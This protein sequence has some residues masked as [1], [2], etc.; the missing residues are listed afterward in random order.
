MTGERQ[1]QI[2][3]G[4][5]QFEAAR[6]LKRFHVSE[7][8]AG[9]AIPAV[10]Y[11]QRKDREHGRHRKPVPATSQNH[12][13][14]P[15]NAPIDRR[16]GRIL[17][18]QFIALRELKLALGDRPLPSPTPSGRSSK[19]SVTS[20]TLWKQRWEKREA[21]QLAGA[22]QRRDRVERSGVVSCIRRSGR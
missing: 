11:W 18:R 16:P 3:D 6:T 4:Q 17:G 8:P 20:S 1:K 2:F 13:R 5:E 21:I 22:R 9:C 7:K 14:K 10:E 15:P 19:Y 12:L